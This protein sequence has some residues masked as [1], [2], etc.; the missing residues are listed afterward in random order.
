MRL[1]PLYFGP[2][3]SVC[4]LPQALHPDVGLRPFVFISC[5]PLSNVALCPDVMG[6]AI[7]GFLG[8]CT[9]SAAPPPASFFPKAC[10]PEAP[11][12]LLLPPADDLVFFR[13]FADSSP[14][15]LLFLRF[16]AI[17]KAHLDISY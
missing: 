2:H 16:L 3:L 13:L 17:P 6:L 12:L 7:A 15:L 9:S 14:S 8:F 5:P 11:L 10:S 4:W 1:Q